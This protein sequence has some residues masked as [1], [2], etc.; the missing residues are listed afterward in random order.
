MLM[1]NAIME[2][3]KCQSLQEKSVTITSQLTTYAI[4]GIVIII[5]SLI[6]VGI[7]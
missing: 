5:N 6:I 1:L 7:L 4:Y 3:V 2:I